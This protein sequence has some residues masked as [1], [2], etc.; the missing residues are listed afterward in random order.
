MELTPKEKAKE[1]VKSFMSIEDSKSEFIK[2]S[3]LL[4]S[5]EAKQ[6]ALICVDEMLAFDLRFFDIEF[7][8]EVKQE[9]NKMEL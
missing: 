7:L 5:T 2:G 8:K 4:T 6:C 9:I 3:V 1:L